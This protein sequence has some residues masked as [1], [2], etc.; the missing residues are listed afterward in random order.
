MT[1]RLG[2]SG[3][4]AHS[5]AG[6]AASEACSAGSDEPE[7]IQWKRGN[8]LGKG[9]YGTVSIDVLCV[10]YL[11]LCMFLLYVT[12]LLPVGVIKDNNWSFCSLL[13]R[14]TEKKEPVFF[15]VHLFST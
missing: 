6:S 5:P 7:T 9:A 14:E 12:V 1:S 11:L 3:G 10:L 15:C 8:V 4:T 13:H 2:R